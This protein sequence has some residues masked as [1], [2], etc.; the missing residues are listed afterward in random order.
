MA[1]LGVLPG[2]ELELLCAGRDGHCM[3]KIN[4]ATLSLDDLSADA[5]LVRRR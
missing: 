5:I 2:T 3:V 4:G 1:N